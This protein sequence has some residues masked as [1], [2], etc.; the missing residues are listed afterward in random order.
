MEV[1][2]FLAWRFWDQ[3][4]HAYAHIWCLRS[5]IP[6]IVSDKNCVPCRFWMQR[7]LRLWLFRS[8]LY[9]STLRCWASFN[10]QSRQPAALFMCR[11]IAQRTFPL[12]GCQTQHC[13][14]QLYN[15]YSITRYSVLTFIVTVDQLPLFLRGVPLIIQDPGPRLTARR[16][17][18]ELSDEGVVPVGLLSRQ[19]TLLRHK[20]R[21]SPASPGSHPCL[22]RKR[23]RTGHWR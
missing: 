3:H 13:Y 1:L 16:A 4:W 22:A 6:A 17:P 11:Y 7:I 8:C 10:A 15:S 5:K 12:T 19:H 21:I 14:A 2:L 20:L 18:I 23:C 9:V